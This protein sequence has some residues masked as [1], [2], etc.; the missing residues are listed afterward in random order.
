MPTATVD[1]YIRSVEISIRGENSWTWGSAPSIPED[2][3]EISDA[4]VAL[5]AY[6]EVAETGPGGAISLPDG[7]ALTWHHLDG[8]GLRD[9]YGASTRMRLAADSSPRQVARAAARY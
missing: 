3:L 6:L 7:Q 9:Q 2:E 4:A 1:S 5:S 8:W